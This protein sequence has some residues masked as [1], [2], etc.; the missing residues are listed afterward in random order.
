MFCVSAQTENTPPFRT[1]QTL[2]A[3]AA[4]LIPATPSFTVTSNWQWD[5]T[6][7]AKCAAQRLMQALGAYG[8]LGEVLGKREFLIHIQPAAKRLKETVEEANILSELSEVLELSDRP[9]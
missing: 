4:K 8:Y 9:V 5:S 1:Q 3:D 7:Y 2:P 6:V